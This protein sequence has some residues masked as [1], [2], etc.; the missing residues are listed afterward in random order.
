MFGAYFDESEKDGA[1]TYGAIVAPTCAWVEF[2]VAW[3]TAMAEGGAAGKTLH[4]KN[5]LHGK[6]GTAS[7]ED[8]T[9]WTEPMRKRLFSLLVPVLTSFTTY[10]YS[11]TVPVPDLDELLRE[12]PKHEQINPTVFCIQHCVE[13][14]IEAVKPS[15]ADP[16]ACFFHNAGSRE[17]DI[18]R[19]FN[20]MR[21]VKGWHD[22]LPASPQFLP[23]KGFPQIQGADMFARESCDDWLRT[24]LRTPRKPRRDLF[25]AILR[26][27][28]FRPQLF[29]RDWLER[30]AASMQ[31]VV[32]NLNDDE[33]EEAS[34]QWRTANRRM[35]QER[36]PQHRKPPPRKS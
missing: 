13:H 20:I 17:P 22:I 16:L 29:P 30:E 2:H 35:Q 31:A 12:G 33:A 18:H 36:N 19:F 27:G 10:G 1:F 4:M 8:Y 26:S 3:E 32:R 28:K 23:A 9:G 21:E 7:D 24:R 5:I 11:A 25:S 34:T 14:I 6:K 15:S